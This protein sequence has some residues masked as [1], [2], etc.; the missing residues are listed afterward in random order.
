MTADPRRGPRP[1]VRLLPTPCVVA[2]NLRKGR[3]VSDPEFDQVY[4]LHQRWVSSRQWT[5]VAI[6]IRAAALLTAGGRK[7]VLDVGS[8]VGKFCITGALT[9]EALFMGVEQRPH[10]VRSARTAAASYGTSR[11]VFFEGDFSQVDFALFDGFY[12]FNPFEE[13]LLNGVVTPIDSTLK[14]SPSWFRRH[15][16]S[17]M[18]K[19]AEARSGTRV[20]TYYGHGG[21]MPPGYRIVLTEPAGANQLILWEKS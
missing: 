9:T 10:L 16:V 8:G 12:L 14:L 19:L 18:R 17:L 21:P 4:S 6:A 15:L 11:A 13:H 3:S 2:G 5:P 7:L 1:S 20:L